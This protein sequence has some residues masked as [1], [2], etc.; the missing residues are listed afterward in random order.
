VLRKIDA[1]TGPQDGSS[2][3]DAEARIEAVVAARR[4]DAAGQASTPLPVDDEIES[5][6][7]ARRTQRQEHSGGFC[8]K[9][10]KPVLVSD[11]F[12]P[13]CGQLLK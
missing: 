11:K 13:N 12:C 8:P 10:G 3:R 7:S 1:L 5:R 2:D 9:C 4:A 6:V